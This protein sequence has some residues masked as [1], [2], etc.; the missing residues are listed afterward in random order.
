MNRRY[1]PA[2]AAAA[3]VVL[4]LLVLRLLRSEAPAVEPAG[5]QRTGG[6]E[7]AAIERKAAYRAPPRP[8]ADQENTKPSEALETTAPAASPRRQLAG[9]LV[10]EFRSWSAIP[11]DYQADNLAVVSGALTLGPAPAAEQARHGSLLSPPLPLRPPPGGKPDNP[12]KEL[13]SGSTVE[14]EIRLS[15]DG[16]SW[17]QWDLVERH[18]APD[19]PLAPLPAAPP[20][21][22][23]LALY[24]DSS[25]TGPRIQYRLSLSATGE[26]APLVRDLRIWHDGPIQLE[27]ELSLHSPSEPPPAQ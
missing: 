11:A 7:T 21:A 24:Q 15:R 18:R 10:D 4:L 3:F 8:R 14:L 5:A 17:T 2:A 26:E 23:T 19:G 6:E 27:D 20:D 25:T 12:G 22:E 1:I 16:S 9:Y 13:P